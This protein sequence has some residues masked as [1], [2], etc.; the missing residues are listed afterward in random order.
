MSFKSFADKLR[1][2]LLLLGLREIVVTPFNINFYYGNHSI[3]SIHYDNEYILSFLI[4]KIDYFQSNVSKEYYDDLSHVDDIINVV[5]KFIKRKKQSTIQQRLKELEK[6]FEPS[7][8][9]QFV[10]CVHKLLRNLCSFLNTKDIWY[11]ITVF[12]LYIVLSYIIYMMYSIY[13][14]L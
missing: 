5:S 10:H 8:W 1:N 14:G 6:D 2:K 13:A 11:A 7:M 4:S 3:I 9:S 12:I